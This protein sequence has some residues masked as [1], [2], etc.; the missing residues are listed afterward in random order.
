MIEVVKLAIAPTFVA[1]VTLIGRRFGPAVAGF[2]AAL[3]VVAAPIL[4][5]IVAQHGTA[6]GAT[7]A[8]AC[9]VGTGPTILFALAF[10]RFAPRLRPVPCLL[11]AYAVYFASAGLALFVPVSWPFA[12]TVP[13]V[14]W[15]LALPAFPVHE[16][17]LAHT[18][19]ARWDLPMRVTATFVMVAT[20]SGLARAL[21]PK[22]A[23]LV[24]PIPIITA[25]LAV[26]SH[27]QGGAATATILLRALVRGI[28]SFVAFFWVVALL[29]PRSGAVA[30]FAA[31][32]A[33]CLT[34][35]FLIQRLDIGAP[36]VVTEASRT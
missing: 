34:L 25:T 14:S 33:L 1:I 22:V 4:G 18:P 27:Q 28:A 7:A 32:L 13:L 15:L 30:A 12:I 35:H 20:V 5:L 3:P 16:P 11:A 9:A 24:T 19:A 8:L 29:L 31:G 26:F 2:L 6:F 10:A 21:G 23:G 36:P 17:R